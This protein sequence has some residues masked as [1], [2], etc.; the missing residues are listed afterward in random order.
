VTPLGRLSAARFGGLSVPRSSCTARRATRTWTPLLSAHGGSGLC[1]SSVCRR[2]TRDH[3][4]LASG[5][6]AVR[7]FLA[8]DLS[9]TQGHVRSP[10]LC[11]ASDVAKVVNNSRRTCPSSRARPSHGVGPLESP[12]PDPTSP[13]KHPSQRRYYG[14]GGSRTSTRPQ[15]TPSWN[16]LRRRGRGR[17]GVVMVV[18]WCSFSWPGAKN[19]SLLFSQRARVRRLRARAYFVAPAPPPLLVDAAWRRVPP[20]GV[21]FDNNILSSSSLQPQSH[22][23]CPPHPPPPLLSPPLLPSSSST[24]ARAKEAARYSGP[25]C[26]SPPSCTGRC[27]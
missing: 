15:A 7:K 13:P 19:H 9:G 20:S 4:C 2:G 3:A 26:R 12:R 24:G 10:Y 16:R 1:V 23:C 17:P 8:A 27:G 14:P 25:P 5:S 22:R 18:G 21:P 6:V 11:L